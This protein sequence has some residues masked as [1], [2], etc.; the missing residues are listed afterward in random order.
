[1]LPS[2]AQPSQAAAAAKPNLPIAQLPLPSFV[3]APQPAAGKQQ[4]QQQQQPHPALPSFALPSFTPPARPATAALPSFSSFRPASTAAATSP[5]IS[6]AALPGFTPLSSAPSA[7]RPQAL[8]F[9]A[10]PHSAASLLVPSRTPSP[11]PLSPS[12]AAPAPPVA[13]TAAGTASL[14]PPHLPSHGAPTS[15]NV[16]SASAPWPSALR[17]LL[18]AVTLSASGSSA[19]KERSTAETT[20]RPSQA[21][22]LI[23]H[24]DTS[25]LLLTANGDGAASLQLT[26]TLHPRIQPLYAI[27]QL[28]LQ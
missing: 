22:R 11:Q 4:R 5:L 17:L 18:P 1:M 19:E 6:A 9:P 2:A 10:P 26:P 24:C 13:G 20:V 15:H 28:A 23:A 8:S 3:P 16:A 25:E 14:R 12:L 7:Q 21:G 27:T